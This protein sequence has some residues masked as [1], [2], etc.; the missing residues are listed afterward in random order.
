MRPSLR[1]PDR[2]LLNVPEALD[3]IPVGFPDFHRAIPLLL[4][5]PVD[6]WHTGGA[7][8]LSELGDAVRIR[9]L[10][11]DRARSAPMKCPLLC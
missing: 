3:N 5:N 11:P 8:S 2:W 10:T 1:A 9:K 4:L 7:K 6:L